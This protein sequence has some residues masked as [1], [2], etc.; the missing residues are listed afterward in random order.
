MDGLIALAVARGCRHVA[1]PEFEVVDPG[2]DVLGREDL[3]ALLLHG[4]W[5][6]STT[7]IRCAA[8]LASQ[9][10]PAG[11]ARAVRRER[12]EAVLRHIA[13]EGARRDRGCEDHW[14][15]ILGELGAGPVPPAGLLPHGT[16][17]VSDPG[18]MRGKRIA[19]TWLRPR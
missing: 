8:Q 9:C 17:F 6:F 10:D 11:L 18:W 19:A 1:V 16:R 5:E 12:G 15:A 3:V 7:A 14:L 4:G 13:T 2:E